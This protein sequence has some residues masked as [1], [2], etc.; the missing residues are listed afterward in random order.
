MSGIV[1]GDGDTKVTETAMYSAIVKRVFF[2]FKG[3]ILWTIK[4]CDKWQKKKN[5][6]IKSKVCVREDDFSLTCRT[7]NTPDWKNQTL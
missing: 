4:E 3:G 5:S 7:I 1:L 6:A 2:F